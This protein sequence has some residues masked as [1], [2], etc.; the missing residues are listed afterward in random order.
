MKTINKCETC[1]WHEDCDGH[2]LCEDYFPADGET[3][4]DVAE[5]A[6]DMA[7]RAEVYDK[8]VDEQNN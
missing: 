3:A 7:I 5:Y 1:I 4:Y 2:S 6:I 8:L